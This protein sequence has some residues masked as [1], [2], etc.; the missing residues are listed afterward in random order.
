MQVER[1]AHLL[2]TY[3]PRNLTAESAQLRVSRERPI[4]R[5]QLEAEVLRRS[6]IASG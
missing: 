6:P 4:A 2:F 5:A 1:V 3:L